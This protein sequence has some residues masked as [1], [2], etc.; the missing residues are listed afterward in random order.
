M[1]TFRHN[2]ATAKRAPVHVRGTTA[3]YLLYIP[4]LK[5][6]VDSIV[7]LVEV[8]EEF[9]SLRSDV[10]SHFCH[11]SLS[12]LTVVVFFL[13]HGWWCGVSAQKLHMGFAFIS[14][15]R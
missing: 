2:H 8:E 7:D 9:E 4:E 5:E 11:I 13:S 14:R 10:M 12:V 3:T 1:P 15:S 6:T